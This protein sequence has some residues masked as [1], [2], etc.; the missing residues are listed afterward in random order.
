MKNLLIISLLL[1]TSIN[2]FA[3]T[4]ITIKIDNSYL[5]QIAASM[6]RPDN[7]PNP[8]YDPGLPLDQ[9]PKTIV[10]PETAAQY[11]ERYFYTDIVNRIIEKQIDL[12]KQAA[13]DAKRAELQNM[14]DKLDEKNYDQLFDQEK[15]TTLTK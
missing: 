15:T 6:G 10:N 1:F 14:N 12:V 8:N 2:C 7:I 9:S 11:I 13:E 5:D 4:T 3:Q